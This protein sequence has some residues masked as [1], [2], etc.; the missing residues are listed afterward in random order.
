MCTGY[1]SFCQNKNDSG[2]NRCIDE[3]KNEN[4]DSVGDVKEIPVFITKGLKQKCGKRFHV[5][6][7]KDYRRKFK[8]YPYRTDLYRFQFAMKSAEYYLIKLWKD[9]DPYSTGYLAIFRCKENKVI[10]SYILTGVFSESMKEVINQR[11]SSTWT[12]A[13]E[14]E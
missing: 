3:I 9:G 4:F 1:I 12:L 10:E 13:R 5:L 6:S 11:N 7:D 8:G 2:I 14:C